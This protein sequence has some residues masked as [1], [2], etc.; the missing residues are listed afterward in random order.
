MSLL[1]NK[2][3]KIKIEERQELHLIVPNLG[4]SR[5]SG[6]DSFRRRAA[7]NGGRVGAGICSVGDGN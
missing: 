3:V 7:T 6:R 4:E 1:L 5:L 2:K